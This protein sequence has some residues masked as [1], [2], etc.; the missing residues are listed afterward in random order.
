M[1]YSPNFTRPAGKTSNIVLVW[2]EDSST[3]G[4]GKTGLAYNTASLT[5]YYV[6]DDGSASVAVSLAD[7]TLGTFTSGGFKEVDA[8]NL[9]GWY[10]FCPPDAALASGAGAVSFCF[11]G[12]AGMLDAS[13]MID[14]GIAEAV[15]TVA[16]AEAYP[17]DGS[18]GT[19]A[20]LVYLILCAISEFAISGTTITGKK[21]DGSTTAATWTLDSATAPSSRTRAS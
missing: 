3:A 4:T 7:M 6:R 20:E 19:L 9:P 1:S 21:L 18:A 15:T 16:L 11:T 13:L 5:C 14:L 8:T 10:Q 2:I 12:G 17:T